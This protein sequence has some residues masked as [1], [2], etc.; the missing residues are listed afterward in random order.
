MNVCVCVLMDIFTNFYMPW[1]INEFRGAHRSLH[2]ACYKARRKESTLHYYYCVYIF[3]KKA[4]AKKKSISISR[5]EANIHLKLPFFLFFLFS[6]NNSTNKGLRPLFRVVSNTIRH[7]Q[8]ALQYLKGIILRN[9][10]ICTKGSFS[11]LS[12]R[13]TFNFS[14]SSYNP[15][16]V[17]CVCVCV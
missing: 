11:R 16:E 17:V 3:K 5:I 9:R 1:W 7:V 12:R 10:Y 13:L 4:Q 14:L 6:F 2:I 15:N 8:C